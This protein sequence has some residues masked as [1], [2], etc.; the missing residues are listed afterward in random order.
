MMPNTALALLLL[1]SAG[2]LRGRPDAGV[3]R[4]VLSVLAALV[5]LAIGAGTLAEYMLGVDLWLDQ[6][7]FPAQG[8]PYPGRPSPPTALALSLLAMALLLFDFR[9]EARAR[10]SEWLA[11][12]AGLTALAALTGFMLGVGPLYRLTDAPV[13]GV[14]VPTALSLLCLSAGLLLERPVW[15]IMRVA[16]SPGPGGVLLRRLVLPALLAPVL[17]GFIINHI[18]QR[19]G[20][21]ESALLVAVLA[22]AMGLVVILLLIVTA[23]PIDRTHAALEA[24]RARTQSLVEQAPDGV[25]VADLDGFYTDVNSAGCR[26]LGYSRQELIGKSI[27]DIILPEDA[28]RLTLSK[29]RLLSGQSDVGEWVLRKK[30]G[31]RVPVEVS[32][33]ILP[34]GR[35]QGLVRD[36]SERK[37]LERSLQRSHAE[38]ARA[39]AVANIG[40]WQLDVCNDV[41][42]WSEQECRIFAVPPGTTTTYE[43]FLALVH[44]DDRGYVDERWAAAL[45]GEPYDIEHRIVVGGDVRWVREKAELEFDGRG[46]LLGGIGIT[47]DITER[48]RL[49]AEQSRARDL[50]RESQQRL[51]L[52]LAGGGLATWD[53]DIGTGEVIFSPRWAE[54]RGFRPEEI[55]PH[56]DSWTSGVHPDDLP[57]L[58]KALAE[59]FE[60]LSPEYR[61]EYRVRN[62]AGQWRWIF[63]LGRVFARDER[64]QPSRMAGVELDISER[65]RFEQELAIAEAKSSGI[66]SIS[67][68]AIISIDEDQ[69][70]TLFNAGAEKIFGYTKAEALGAP[71]DMLVPPRHRSAHRQHVS[72][73]AAAHEGARRM[74]AERGGEI[75]GLRKNGEEFPADAA[76]SRL[77]VGGQ[78]I[79]TVALRD[80]TQQ[81]QVENEQRFL[82]QFGAAL[83]ST[84]DYEETARH[85]AG[86]IAGGLSDVCIVETESLGEEHEQCRF[87]AHREPGQAALAVRLERMPI[88]RSRPYL[89]SAVF[90]TRHALL[91]S[92]VTPEYLDSIAQNE[93]QREVLREL[94]PKSLA[95]LPLCTGGA[96]VG[97]II[98]LR[99]TT[100]RAYGRGE[101][102]FLENVAHRAALVLE[103]ARLYSV[104][105]HAIQMRDDVL[106]IVAH[107]LRNPLGAI[108]IQAALLG[109]RAE[110]PAARKPSEV[111]ERAAK[112]M[113]RLIQDLLDVARMEGGRL[114]IEQ[115][116]ITA[117]QAL[118][119]SARAEEALAASAALE[120]RLDVAPD[121]PEVW[122]DHDRLLQIFENLI[123]NA[124]KFTDPGGRITLGAA[125]R[126]GEVLFWVA[127][128][129]GG[130]AAEDLPHVFERFWQA[131]KAGRHGAGLGLPIVKGI[132]EAHGGRIW[133]ESTL[134]RGTCFFF[135]IPTAA[136][137]QTSRAQ[138]PPH[139]P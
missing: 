47:Q 120:L 26:M 14:A 69:R 91:V 137:A 100:A 36:I 73:F 13:I 25:F 126:D 94:A 15:G 63:D 23:V 106:G 139:A 3:A 51:E 24:S 61:A 4:R 52:A 10:P 97:A 68:D 130:I 35:W 109:R 31:G 127:D 86:Q 118:S 84:L 19:L 55:R 41:L 29:T 30:D 11:L 58:Q 12:S 60:G 20:I 65:K 17:L 80:I 101:L 38:L 123:G 89:G 124:I 7:L 70:I 54:M 2:A 115:Q 132:V 78:R 134:G 5:V 116:R 45:R 122:A 105:R 95:A 136:R 42:Q 50:I 98:A 37:R 92:E 18:S 111:I 107:D 117:R 66:L 121:L 57:G 110:E 46:A 49:E 125:P 119:E 85:V 32:A 48:K 135:T 83:A 96:V 62:R 76:I 8:G 22:S 138:A 33:R 27:V 113:N 71:L 77:E 64:G 6:I 59:H 56:V 9:A 128:T 34:D 28:P 88:D 79:L 114:S 129:G 21:Q 43:A 72:R 87:V 82:A 67:P 40:S 112:R 99:T 90:G 104:A 53:W 93:E 103:K 16:T 74:A 108:L 131:R 44:P 102:P 81:K 75:W 39:Q 1:G 133:A